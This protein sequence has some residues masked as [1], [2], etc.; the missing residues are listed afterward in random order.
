MGLGALLLNT[1]VGAAT[2]GS[3]IWAAVAI[4]IDTVVIVGANSLLKPKLP[5]AAAAPVEALRGRTI[6]GRAPTADRQVAYGESRI[7][8]QVV[9]METTGTKS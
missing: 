1:L 8:G 9:F 3:S 7:G 2:V 5:R 4:V 6:N